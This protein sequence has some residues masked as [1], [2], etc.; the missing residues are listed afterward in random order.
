MDTLSSELIVVRQLPEIEER[1]RTVKDSVIER[2]SAALAM[3]LSLI[4]I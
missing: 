3:V 1:L 2:V 4:H